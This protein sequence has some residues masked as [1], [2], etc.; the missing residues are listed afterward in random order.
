MV[1]D[2]V[3]KLASEMDNGTLERVI[4]TNP[5]DF[6]EGVYDIYLNEYKSRNLD[7]KDFNI[8][9]KIEDIKQ[10]NMNSYK[11]NIVSFGYVFSILGGLIGIIIAIYLLVKTEDST[12]VKKRNIKHGITMLVI[13]I[14]MMTIGWKIMINSISYVVYLIGSLI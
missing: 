12:E 13:A 11:A 5:A 3:I 8:E 7:K 1:N 4:S 2:D 10:K 14:F 6:K 9:E